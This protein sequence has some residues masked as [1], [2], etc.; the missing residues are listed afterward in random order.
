[1][2]PANKSITLKHLLIEGKKQIGLKFYPCKVINALI[3]KLEDCSW[4]E[5]FGLHYVPN[6]KAHLEIIFKTF[7]G[8]AWVDCRYFFV[9]RPIKTNLQTVDLQFLRKRDEKPDYRYCP[10]EY[11]D[12]LEI[13][14]YAINTVKTYVHLFEEFI[15]HFNEPDLMQIN[16]LQIREYLMQKMRDGKSDSYINQ[17]LNSIKFYY[18]VVKEMPNRF[19]AIER[20]MKRE[21]LPVVLSKQS[22]LTMINLPQ[23]IKHKCIIELLYSAGLRRAELLD[24]KVTDI[25]SER[26]LI[27]VKN[28]KGGKDRVTLLGQKTLFDLRTYYKEYR[29]SHYLFEGAKGK[30]Y[31]ETSVAIIVK[32]AAYRA[33]IRKKVTPH[34]LRHSFATHLLEQGV[35][36]RY[37]QTLLGH[38]CTRTTEIYTRVANDSFKNIKNLLD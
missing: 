29:P 9:N 28:G 16:E 26:M 19:Y 5:H 20:P 11:L 24:L 17:A 12:K 37:I 34:T 6:D 27:N 38:N 10:S 21:K 8:V 25:D 33:G 1:M 23:N 3:E 22:V 18:E 36:L 14:R 35:D 31:S 13:R 15:N 30:K 7:R 32:K 4:S 2:N